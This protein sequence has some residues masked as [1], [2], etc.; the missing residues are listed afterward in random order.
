MQWNCGAVEWWSSQC[1]CGEE[2]AAT[3]GADPNAERSGQGRSG[4]IRAGQ[5]WTGTT[6]SE[7]EWHDFRQKPDTNVKRNR[8]AAAHV[9]TWCSSPSARPGK[10]EQT[11]GTGRTRLAAACENLQQAIR[12]FLARGYLGWPSL[13]RTQPPAPSSSKS[14]PSPQAPTSPVALS[15]PG[16]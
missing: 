5:V 1:R 9:G 3:A 10:E 8:P 4:Q 15:G 14:I 2:A 11:A 7:E 13:C 16:R 6:E 12:T